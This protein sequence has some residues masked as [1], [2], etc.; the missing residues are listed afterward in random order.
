MSII[1]STQK[2]KYRTFCNNEKGIPI[3]SKDWWLD[4][5]CGKD[6]WDV[7]LVER[8]GKIVASMPYY[9]KKSKRNFFTSISMPPLTQMLGPYIIY[10]KNQK[11][12]RRLSF[13]KEIMNELIAQ[14]PQFDQFTQYFHYSVTNWLPFY[15]K[16]YSQTAR[17]T[18]IIEDV[19]N[20]DLVW[21][22]FESSTRRAISVAGKSLRCYQSDDIELFYRINAMSFRRQNISVPY[23][24]SFVTKIDENLAKRGN[25]M[26]LFA[27]DLCDSVHAVNYLVWDDRSVYFL[28]G[29]SD[30]TL[31][32]SGADSLLTWE[33]IKL[34]SSLQKKVEFTGSMIESVER[35]FRSFGAVQKQ[36]FKIS[37]VNSRIIRFMNSVNSLL[38]L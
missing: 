5:V 4:A 1:I 26:I 22:G 2:E 25:R 24:F 10:P 17:Y 15:W 35:Y 30:P 20:L 23:S 18:Y 6:N 37:K 3:F 33:S 34:A 31:R 7:V 14:F 19:S 16:G 38:L 36:Y 9:V 8:G 28:M 13:E 21:E 11:Y 27:A 32:N 29:G 12:E